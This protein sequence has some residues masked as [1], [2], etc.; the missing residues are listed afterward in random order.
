M[1]CE[2]Y[3][4]NKHASL[5]HVNQFHGMY[6]RNTFVSLLNIIKENMWFHILQSIFIHKIQLDTHR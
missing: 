6:F 4:P 3:R 5:P 1:Q 2:K